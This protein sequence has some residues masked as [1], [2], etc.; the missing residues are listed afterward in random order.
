M[1][2]W[3][4]VVGIAFTLSLL[5]AG[6]G[7]ADPAGLPL[8]KGGQPLV[9]IVLPAET[10]QDARVNARRAAIP[11]EVKARFPTMTDEAKL[12]AQVKL[13]QDNY[14][15][16]LAQTP[17]ADEERLAA[18]ELQ[19]I[20]AKISGAKLEIV[21]APAGKLPDGPAIVLGTT[22]ARLAGC[23]A[24]VDQ[25]GPDGILLKVKGP[26]LVLA[27]SRARGT[28]YAAYE[29]LESFGCRWVMP[30]PFGECY[31]AAKDLTARVDKV[32]EPSHRK[33]YFWCTYGYGKEFPRWTLRTKGNM[34]MAPGD[35]TIAQGH[36]LSGPL[37]WGATNPKYAVPGKVTK[38]VPKKQPDGTTVTETVEEDGLVLPDEYFAMV[39]NKPFHSV[40]NM[41]SE[42]AV[43]LYADYYLDYFR[44]NPTTQYVSISAEDGL[45]LDERPEAKRL[46]SYEYDN[47][48]GAFSA[49][50]RMWHFHNRVIERVIKEFPDRKFG[51]LVYANNMAPP[52]LERVHPN[53]ALVIAPLG[54]SPLHHVRDPKSKTNRVY[55]EWLESWMAQ[56]A[57][58]GAETYYYDY[59]PTGYCW[60]VGLLCPRWGIIGQNYPWFHQLGLDGHTTQGHD[61]WGACGLDN[62]LMQRLYWDVT[63]DYRAVIA[64]YCRARFG[65]AGPAMETYYRI[66]EDRMAEIPDLYSNEVW[67]NHLILTPEV[68]AKGR[69]QLEAAVKLADSDHARAQLAAA[70]AMQRSTD[71][72]CDAIEHARATAD[73]GA[74]AKMMAVT[75]EV[76]E[77][78]N[79]L[80]SH[81]M[82]PN[83]TDPKA[84]AEY[85]TGGIYNQYL[86]FERKT[87]G[88]KAALALPR[89]WQMANDTSNVA[90]AKGWT[91]PGQVAAP[92]LAD[93]DVTVCPDV[94]FNSQRDVAAFFYRAEVEIPQD[95]AGKQKFVWYF[96][97]IIAR[98]LQVWI[99]GKEV[100]FDQ[101]GEKDTI[102]RGPQ[103]FWYDYNH[104]LQFDITPYVKPGQKQTLCFR[105]FKSHDFGGTYR[106]FY[107]LADPVE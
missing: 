56:A 84:K 49:T 85:L 68:R 65:A 99:D 98:A 35:Q 72:I 8:V 55:R 37:R 42:K 69:A 81:F 4:R 97:S 103:Y 52:R 47:F 22:L 7:A 45:V 6:G 61:D 62:Y 107:L 88:A 92:E 54:I 40:P 25:L 31:P 77:E 66:Y 67:A 46:E 15:K 102:W 93:W 105:V 23:G 75:F 17:D 70:V 87:R 18:A 74:A 86:E 76:R 71:A 10:E 104:Q 80:Y 26:Y 24:E 3:P 9:T 21:A 59:E 63:Q 91:K 30:G 57:A 1:S 5:P 73:F 32:Q 41:A 19:E 64:D 34:V 12:A 83:R 13:A 29:L 20:I 106:R 53:M 94:K 82:Q 36:A 58:V 96:P 101:K 39:G 78:L 2:T 95:F 38:K 100:V 28:L 33:R 11:G 43:E 89:T 44:K 16:Q 79:K 50:D 60:N 90:W 51:V 48:I 27:G 14:T